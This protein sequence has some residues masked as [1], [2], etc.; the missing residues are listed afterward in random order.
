MP[1][2]SHQTGDLATPIR[3]RRPNEDPPSAG[4]LVVTDLR[5]TGWS[6]G[7]DT[8]ARE[9]AGLLHQTGLGVY[10]TYATYTDNRKESPYR[11]SS[12]TG[13]EALA[14]FSGDSAE[15]I[16]T[17]N[18]LLAA[19]G[20]SRF[21]TYTVYLPGKDGRRATRNRLHCFLLDR[22]PH[23]SP[24]DVLA[25]LRLAL[26]DPKVYKYIR[27]LFRPTFRPIDRATDAEGAPREN[28]NPW[29][30]ILP[31]IKRSAEWRAL[32][33]RAEKD[34]L[35][36][37]ERNL[38]GVEAA[39]RRHTERGPDP[40]TILPDTDDT[41]STIVRNTDDAS[42]IRITDPG[43]PPILPATEDGPPTRLPDT[44]GNHDQESWNQ[45]KPG[46]I[47]PRVETTT[48]TRAPVISTPAHP[49]DVQPYSES[50]PQPRP[51]SPDHS[52]AT[53]L[54]LFG[55][56]NGRAANPI[57]RDLLR[58][59]AADFDDP[60]RTQAADSSG[61]T[62]IMAAIVEA[63]DAGS[64][65][66][67]PR[68]VRAIC[69]RWA[70]DGFRSSGSR[71]RHASE[72]SERLPWLD[73][74]DI[75]MPN[76]QKSRTVWRRVVG[77]ARGSLNAD[78]LIRYLEPC[79]ISAYDSWRDEVEITVPDESTGRKLD[80]TF[81]G[82]IERALAMIFG[83]TT[84]FRCRV[85]TDESDRGEPASPEDTDEASADLENDA[86]DDEADDPKS[87]EGDV[88]TSHDISINKED[89][90]FIPPGVPDPG[91]AQTIS[92][93]SSNETEPSAMTSVVETVLVSE[94][95]R[96]TNRQA[97]LL[98]LRQ[99]SE[100]V[101]PLRLHLFE[102]QATL[103][104]WEDDAIRVIAANPFV[105]EQLVKHADVLEAALAE[106][107][108]RDRVMLRYAVLRR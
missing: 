58:Q 67:S 7:W 98:A 11:G 66:V 16:R 74:P 5:K 89:V 57:E 12:Y 48:T 3:R 40:T 88:A 28:P 104:D 63:V 92:D 83:Q 76:G 45:R 72:G 35:A 41:P 90:S 68:R 86:A 93:E 105:A 24:N 26:E 107:L 60:A 108:G 6:W 2:E 34:Y 69:E 36:L 78:T 31:L 75:P 64:Q 94:S 4:E 80:S 46:P 47:T 62:W 102:A 82:A 51:L 100:S 29:Y 18:K 54:D 81:R 56:A 53:V 23:L 73:V 37:R 38:H 15:D 1:G 59:I 22:D 32:T 44:D 13:V 52:L 65:F 33:L 70:R 17:I 99:C 103:G 20:L 49:P 84:R 27:H 25:V 91:L 9:F 42:S 30:R 43:S 61:A 79:V 39:A 96:L 87:L 21:E 50:R 55:Q 14:D 71:P 19:L 101:S 106:V 8:L 10:F 95:P 85:K 97:W 77:I